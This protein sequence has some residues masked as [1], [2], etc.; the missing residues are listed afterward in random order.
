MGFDGAPDGYFFPKFNVFC[1]GL[2]N[3]AVKRFYQQLFRVFVRKCSCSGLIQG[4]VERNGRLFLTGGDWK[5]NGIH[6]QNTCLITQL[7]F[8][9]TSVSFCKSL[10]TNYVF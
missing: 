1:L 5:N 6:V 8:L 3:R 9:I 10:M 7:L 4:G 2:C